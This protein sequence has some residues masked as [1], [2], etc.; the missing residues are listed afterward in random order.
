MDHRFLRVATL[1]C[2]LMLAFTTSSPC[3]VCAQSNEWRGFWADAFGDG[4][5]SAS[6]VTTFIEKVRAA[7]ANAIL[8][9]IRKRG[10]A[11]YNGS[12]YEPKAMDVSPSTFD[13]LADTIA[14]AHDTSCG[15]QRIE[16]HA[17]IVSYKIWG[18]LS[19]RP[20]ASNPPHPYNAHS[21]WLTQDVK[22]AL[23]DGSSY[24]FDPGH[25]D[26][27]LYT[28]N[29]CTDIISRYDIDGF[30]LDYIRYTG[31]TWGYHPVTVARFNAHY[32]RT[33]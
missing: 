27:Q 18:S 7:N 9:E 32:A 24:S 13:P 1:R 15:K 20:P 26:V 8:P 21:D 3:L 23:W 17:W 28:F 33:G 5:N 16:V 2:S 22:G 14:K 19:T 10:D 29:I 6:E 4:F 12:I 31:N 30:N 11:Y 25:P